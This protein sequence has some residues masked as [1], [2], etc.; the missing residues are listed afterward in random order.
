MYT[1]PRSP[2]SSPSSR[3]KYLAIISAPSVATKQKRDAEWKANWNG[4]DWT[5][6]AELC[7]ENHVK[8]SA[9]ICGAHTPN[10]K[11]STAVKRLK[12]LCK[13]ASQD[14]PDELWF[15]PPPNTTLLLSG[16]TI[17]QA[18]AVSPPTGISTAG[19]TENLVTPSS[20]PGDASTPSTLANQKQ[21]M[22]MQQQ[23]LRLL[24]AQAGRQNAGGDAKGG[25]PQLTPA[26]IASLMTAAKNGQIDM[27]NPA[28]QQ[29]KHLI[30][31]QQQQKQSQMSANPSAA[32]AA[33]AASGT[34]GHLPPGITPSN[35]EQMIQAAVKSQQ[36]AQQAGQGFGQGHNGA[37][38]GNNP[39][40]PQA[41]NQ[42]SQVQTPANK[43]ALWS[44]DLL[45][46]L[47]VTSANTATCAYL[48]VQIREC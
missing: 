11:D 13:D 45:W 4:L 15:T 33:A 8:C 48:S 47:G 1:P 39:P 35:V 18:A 16:Y 43:S 9:I 26:L 3:Q 21:Q 31:L 20:Q 41:S 42:A 19:S 24:Q 32:M 34:A 46:L 23:A 30:M 37:G 2:P 36:L 7:R 40:P 38:M 29:F 14:V 44:G 27:N 10:D 6:A 17:E 5:A 25:V 28:F 12:V 22:F